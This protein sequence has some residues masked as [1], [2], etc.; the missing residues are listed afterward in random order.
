MTIIP[1]GLKFFFQKVIYVAKKLNSN[2]SRSGWQQLLSDHLPVGAFAIGALA[3]A[4]FAIGQ[5]E[6]GTGFTRFLEIGEA[7]RQRLRVKKL[8]VE[9]YTSTL[10]PDTWSRVIAGLPRDHVRR[11][12]HLAEPDA[13]T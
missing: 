6:L 4:G 9:D 1:T 3:S 7:D 13:T 5:L 10:P 2:L 12:R 11:V 8:Q